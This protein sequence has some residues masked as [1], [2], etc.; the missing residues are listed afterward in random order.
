MKQK[1]KLIIAIILF[2]TFT[3][4]Q[5]KAETKEEI[6]LTVSSD[7]TTKD[8]ALKNA[9]RTVIEQAYGAFVSANTTILNDELVKDEIVTVSNG[10]IKD[11]KEISSFEKADGSGYT[12][13]VNTTVSLPHLITYAKSHGSE[14]E[15]AGTTFGM[16]LKLFNLQKEN[17]LKALYNAIPT[18]ENLAKTAMHWELQVDEPKI[19]DYEFKMEIKKS[20]EYKK[21]KYGS[22]K[23][24][25]RYDQAWGELITSDAY[26]D[27]SDPFYFETKIDK[28]LNKPVKTPDGLPSV[29]QDKE[30]IDI[31]KKMQ[32]GQYALVRFRLSWLPNQGTDGFSNYLSSLF[33]SLS[34]D[35]PTAEKYQ[36][37][38]HDLCMNMSGYVWGLGPGTYF[39]FR[40]SPKEMAIWTDSVLAVINRVKN[41]FE[42][43]DNTQ[44]IS[45]FNP[46]EV[47]QW[48]YQYY[49]YNSMKS[50]KYLSNEQKELLRDNLPKNE[51]K[52]YD[53]GAG[54]ILHWENSA[55]ISDATY[56]L[57]IS[58][59][60]ITTFSQ[61]RHGS[62]DYH[63]NRLIT[64]NGKGLFN[65]VAYVN[66]TGDFF[67]PCDKFINARGNETTQITWIAYT[68]IPLSEISKY[69]TFKVVSKE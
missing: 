9:L 16:D 66:Y 47:S 35:Y 56:R 18:I 33:N 68:F 43:I 4:I 15:F 51:Y 44:Q 58:G 57:P 12:I 65:N 21:G 6:T 30:I 62:E 60:K 7:G 48:I 55:H 32:N 20:I 28:L 29:E 10:S 69:S 23:L 25:Y 37:Q 67:K 52:Y 3:A 49:P 40:N 45:S 38:G 11:Y 24:P 39:S 63:I 17:E 61:Y 5:V 54:S 8:E 34:I 31:L 14:C 2:A 1:L 36:E 27:R 46:L 13:T 26:F 53:S 41:N 64:I 59:Q 22:V 19:I 42:I 50:Y